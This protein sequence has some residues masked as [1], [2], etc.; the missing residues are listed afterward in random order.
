MRGGTVRRQRVCAGRAHVEVDDVG[1][2]DEQLRTVAAVPRTRRDQFAVH[3][4]CILTKTDAEHKHT[5]TGSASSLRTLRAPRCARTAIANR[6]RRRPLGPQQLV[7]D[8]EPQPV[9]VEL[10]L[11]DLRC[12]IADLIVSFHFDRF[13]FHSMMIS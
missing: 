8:D 3:G 11:L 4:I 5:K 10:G 1:A 12:L 2:S 7:V 6:T 13:G 9:H